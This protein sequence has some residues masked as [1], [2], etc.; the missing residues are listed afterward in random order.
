MRPLVWKKIKSEKKDKKGG[1]LILLLAV[2]ALY[3]LMSVTRGTSSPLHESPCE[4]PVLIQVEGDVQSPGIY[5]FCQQ[6]NLQSLLKRLGRPGSMPHPPDPM[7]HKTVPSGFKILI[8]KDG[9]GYTFSIMEMSAFSKI[10]LGLPISLN[11][12]NEEGLTALPG[13]GPALA[14]AIV[15]ERDER[16]GFKDLDEVKE[17]EGVGNKLL[18]KIKPF[19]IL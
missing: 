18:E 17:V 16:G 15:L 4:N 9:I 2:L 6:P 14:R 5:T 10:T 12:E 11:R 3:W 1:F 13:V 19:L 7:T 8:Q